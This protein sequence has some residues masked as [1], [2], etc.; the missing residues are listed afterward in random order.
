MK[1]NIVKAYGLIAQLDILQ[2]ECGEL[3][4]AA[5]HHKRAMG[6]GYAIKQTRR[7]TKETL[8]REIAHVMNAMDSV[9]YLLPVPIERIRDEIRK[10]D[11]MTERNLK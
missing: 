5:N 6:K 3:I 9:I 7:E 10:S 2:E 8:I 1:K 11:E 4:R